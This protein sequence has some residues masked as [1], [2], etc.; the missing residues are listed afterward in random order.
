MWVGTNSD[1]KFTRN[2]LSYLAFRDCLTGSLTAGVNSGTSFTGGTGD[3]YFDGSLTASGGQTLGGSDNLNGGGGTDT[4]SA[5]ISGTGT[6]SPTLANIENISTTFTAGGT[7]SLLNA[8]GAT[9]I[10]AVNSTGGT[11][12][13]TNIGSLTGL[14]LKVPDTSQ[15]ASFGFTTAA[16]AGTAD[17]VALSLA[18]VTAGRRVCPA[19]YPPV[20]L[21][22]T[23][24]C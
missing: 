14:T 16:V 12:T 10:E 21:F 8:T 4:L 9:S 13:F 3:D 19:V 11:A 6:Y 1:T 20:V 22:R 17:S 23:A 18:N 15:S 5:I 2:S 24:A 7:L